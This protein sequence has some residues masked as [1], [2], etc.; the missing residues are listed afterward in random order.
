MSKQDYVHVIPRYVQR[1]NIGNNQC[2]ISRGVPLWSSCILFFGG[3]IVTRVKNGTDI[4][5][6]LNFYNEL[7]R[8]MSINQVYWWRCLWRGSWGERGVKKDCRR[9]NA[10]GWRSISITV[11]G[12]VRW[13][14]GVEMLHV[15]WPSC[16]TLLYSDGIG[17]K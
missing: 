5:Q 11:W 16:S 12:V 4:R 3:V 13:W 15:R 8:L 9:R 17:R 7:D 1:S 10:F 14:W 6:S 2:S